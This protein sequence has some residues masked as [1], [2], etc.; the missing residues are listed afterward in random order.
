[1]NVTLTIQHDDV[2]KAEPIDQHANVEG[3]C[4]KCKATPFSV[5]GTGKV[6][7]SHDTYAAE[8]VCLACKQRVGVLRAQVDTIFGIEEDERALRG[9]WKVY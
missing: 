4:P 2:R 5:A 7:E 3:A 6:P 8:A 1:M 9:P